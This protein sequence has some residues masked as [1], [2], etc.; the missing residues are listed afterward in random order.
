MIYQVGDHFVISSRNVWVP[1]CYADEKTAR[2]AFQLPNE[3]LQSLQDK[4]NEAAG[5]TGGTITAAMLADAR[6]A[7]RAEKAGAKP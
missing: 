4:A 2:A 1:G 6:R 7:H 5:G 3:V